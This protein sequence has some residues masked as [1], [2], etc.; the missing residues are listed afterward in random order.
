MNSK[1]EIAKER[2]Q[3]GAKFNGTVYGKRANRNNVDVHIYLDGQYVYLARV[4]VKEAEEYK[5]EVSAY[6]GGPS[7][8]TTSSGTQM[9]EWYVN[10]RK[11]YNNLTQ[12]EMF[13]IY[14]TDFE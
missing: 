9:H 3:N 11:I 10:G 14:G 2:I 12:A 4:G 5:A 7:K 13:A 8:G 6:L 1:I